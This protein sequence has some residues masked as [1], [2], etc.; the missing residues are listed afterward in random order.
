MQAMDSNT[1]LVLRTV[2]RHAPCT[3]L[4]LKRE[5]G[6]SMSAVLRAVDALEGADW[7]EVNTRAVP[8]G[9]KPHAVITPGARAVYGASADAQGYRLCALYADGSQEMRQVR[10]LEGLSPLVVAET[11][12]DAARGIACHLALRGGD[13]YVNEDLCLYRGLRPPVALGDLPSPMFDTIR[14]TYAQAMDRGTDIQKSRLQAELGLWIGRLYGVKRV[15]FAH[16]TA[17]SPCQAAAW[18][19]AYRL[20]YAYL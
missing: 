10:T 6:L 18:E 5:S 20:L 19:A 4:C 11:R 7:I 3:K 1:A 17:L 9:G 14:L 2:L 13:A 15:C 16:E 8:S 12:A